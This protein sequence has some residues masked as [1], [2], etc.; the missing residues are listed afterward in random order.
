MKKLLFIL[1][2]YIGY[3]MAIAGVVSFIFALGIKSA[4]KDNQSVKM[5]LNQQV[6]LDSLKSLSNQV[7]PLKIEFK[8]L[9]ENFVESRN[10]TKKAFNGLRSVVLDYISKTPGMTIE[11]FKQYMESTEELKKNEILLKSESL[12]LK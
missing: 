10:E 8:T 4:N 9:N 7:Q 11:Q 3:F 1:K 6:I 5:E 2:D 12:Q